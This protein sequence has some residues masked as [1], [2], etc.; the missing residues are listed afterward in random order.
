MKKIALVITQPSSQ[1]V[2]WHLANRETGKN[3][4]AAPAS[5]PS[6]HGPWAPP[7][8]KRLIKERKMINPVQHS[9]SRGPFPC[10]QGHGLE[11][12]ALERK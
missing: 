5:L 6:L 9:F 10:L 11:T 12:P 4:A 3:S 8:Q 2:N 1:A 7:T